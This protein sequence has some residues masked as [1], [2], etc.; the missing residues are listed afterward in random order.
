MKLT[1]ESVRDINILQATGEMTPENFAVLKA[2]VKKLFKDGKNKIILELPESDSISPEILR[3]LAVLNLTA[4]ELAGQIILAVIEP[5]TR[6]KID[7]FSKPPAV[8]CF[9]TRE[10]AIQSF[11]PN[12]TEPTHDHPPVPIA[13]ANVLKAEIR[14]SEL[15]DLG[16]LRK[17]LVEL[18]NENRE[19]SR[20]ITEIILIR[21][22]PPDLES[23]K[24][25]VSELEKGIEE[26]MQIAEKA[27]A[28]K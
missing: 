5:L 9:A 26:A 14:A 22:D 7:S 11:H 3:E 6:A 20:R 17:R 19:L 12:S 24:T 10:A 25:K 4:A 1:L 2:G 27:V 28:K 21:R 18:E 8:R 16:E 23:W 15:G 13:D